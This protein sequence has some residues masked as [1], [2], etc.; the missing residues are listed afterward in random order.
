MLVKWDTLKWKTRIAITDYLIPM[1]IGKFIYADPLQ[2]SKISR[3]F[4]HE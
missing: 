2:V 1:I 3:F 4:L